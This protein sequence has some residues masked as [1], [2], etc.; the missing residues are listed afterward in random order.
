MCKDV[1]RTTSMYEVKA[2]VVKAV[3]A[4]VVAIRFTLRH[5]STSSQLSWS[6]CNLQCLRQCRHLVM[7]NN[8][9]FRLFA[10]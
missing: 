8:M 3:V 9:A 7:E 4:G 6:A 2:A 5:I 1:E 10:H